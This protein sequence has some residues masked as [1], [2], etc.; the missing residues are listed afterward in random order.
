MNPTHP[1]P[2]STA[3][4]AV[5]AARAATAQ[6]VGSQS[7]RAAAARCPPPLGGQ[8]RHRGRCRAGS[9]C[10]ASPHPARGSRQQDRVTE[11]QLHPVGSCC[12]GPV[13]HHGGSTL[14]A[15]LW[16]CSSVQCRRRQAFSKR[17]ASS[18]SCCN[19]CCHWAGMPASAPTCSVAPKISR[20][21]TASAALDASS[22]SS[23]SRYC[24]LE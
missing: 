3:R 22:P 16:P 14:Q 15:L 4:P 20:R 8:M 12:M 1:T 19:Y 24:S 5:A 18:Q 7:P 2:P 21:L 10:A 23:S 17:H 9:Q 13:V 11:D 6:P